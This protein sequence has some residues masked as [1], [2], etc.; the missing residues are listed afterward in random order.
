MTEGNESNAPSASSMTRSASETLTER[1]SEALRALRALQ[2]SNSP[3]ERVEVTPAQAAVLSWVAQ[4][5]GAGVTELA[6]GCGI[7]KAT[8]SATLDRLQQRA[9]L[10]RQPREHDK[11]AVGLY[12]GDEGRELAEAINRH[13]SANMEQ[14]LHAL[15]REERQTLVELLEKAVAGFQKG[16]GNGKCF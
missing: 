15:S 9:L 11:R 14:L 16:H 7:T 3:A 5:E 12:L 10:Y 8:A 13:R 6:H 1:L 2:F 4:H